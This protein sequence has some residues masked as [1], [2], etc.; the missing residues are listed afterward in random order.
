VVEDPNLFE[1]DPQELLSKASGFSLCISYCT[2]IIHSI[3][4]TFGYVHN[5]DGFCPNRTTQK[6]HHYSFINLGFILCLVIMLFLNFIIKLSLLLRFYCSED[7]ICTI[8]VNLMIKQDHLVLN[9]T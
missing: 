4:F 8:V 9:R 3:R 5:F 6:Y 7:E 1:E 2:Q